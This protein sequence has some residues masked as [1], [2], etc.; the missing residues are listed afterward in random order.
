MRKS[1][2]DTEKNKKRKRWYCLA[3]VALA[4]VLCAGCFNKTAKAEE[5]AG[6]F[7]QD[8][9]EVKVSLVTDKNEYL[10]GET[11]HYTLSIQNDRTTWNIREMKIEYEFPEGMEPS[12]VLM[13]EPEALNY[14]ET[15]TIEGALTGDENT[16]PASGNPVQS[17]TEK[18]EGDSVGTAAAIAGCVLI[19]IAAVYLI[20]R[21]KH[22][23]ENKKGGDNGAAIILFIAGELLWWMTAFP[24]QAYTGDNTITVRPY[25]TVQYAGREVTIRMIVQMTMAQE[26]IEFMGEDKYTP[27]TTSCHDPSIFKDSDG[28]Y[29]IFGTHMACSRSTDLINWENCDAEFRAGFTDEVK[30]EIRAWNDDDKNGNW[31]GYLWAPDVIYNENL[32]KYCMYLSADGDYWVSNIVMLTADRVMGPYEYAGTV[33]Y[34]GFTEETFGETDAPEVLGTDTIPERY[35]TNGVANRKWGDAY[36][37]CIDPCIIRDDEGNL[38]MSYGSWS[39]GIF[40]LHLDEETGLRDTTVTYSTDAHSDAYFGKKIAGGWYVTGEGSYVQKIGDYYYLF[41]SYGALEAKGGYNIRIYRSED[42]EGPYVDEL[43]NS[44]LYD[45]YVLNINQPVGIRL[46]GGYKWRS[47]TTG[48]VAQGHNSVLVDDDARAFIVYH[49][50]MTRDTEE[51]YVK[52]HQLFTTKEGWLVAAPYQTNGERLPEGGIS[53]SDL[54]GS[55][56]IMLHRMDIDYAAKDVVT[57]N[58]AVLEEDGSVSGFY[59]GSWSAEEGT[60]YIT[61]TL[62]GETYSGVA[63]RMKIENSTVETVVFTALG[64]GNQVTIWGSKC[65]P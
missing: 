58:V 59:E 13:E 65:L 24:T 10:A 11:L 26:K 44:P 30:D 12:D 23:T 54:A 19:V 40:L 49:T 2:T 33:V 8:L 9:K 37:N 25:V 61:I 55:Y 47:F 46:F 27:R 64:T 7:Y 41:I 57:S 20:L 35:I 29:Y 5:T 1:G 18:E 50:R 6:D 56:E 63:L 21:K 62:N 42:P 38:L 39:G 3:G 15:L 16:Y 4:G 31:F 53:A 45:E 14:G 36:P 17:L 52:V 43:G 32:Q 22:K 60:P 34:G 51:H 28:T 48:Q